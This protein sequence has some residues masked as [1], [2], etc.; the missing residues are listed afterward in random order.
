MASKTKVFG[1]ASCQMGAIANDGGMGTSLED[2]GETVSGTASMTTEDNTVTDFT[3]EETDSPVESIVSAFGKITFA[4]STYNVGARM[5]YKFFGGTLKLFKTIATLGSVTGGSGYTNGTYA[6]VALTGGT[7]SGAKATIVVASGAVSTVTITD[8]GEGFTVA[9]ALSAAA[10]TIGGT[11][12]G[13]SVPVA[14]LSN[15]SATNTIWEAPDSFPDL[16]QSLKLTDKKGNVFNLPRVKIS[17]KFGFSFAKDKLGQ[18][19]LS[20]TILQPTKSGEKRIT[21]TYAN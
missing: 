3:C 5:L 19:D 14:T 2:V 12:T 8:G 1:L 10:S 9:D 21:V 7:G 4:W 6:G 16:E 18:I 13:F 20:A 11:G 15:G 17:G